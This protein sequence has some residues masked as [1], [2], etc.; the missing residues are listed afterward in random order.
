[1]QPEWYEALP[2]IHPVARLFFLTA[3]A[4][5]G[6][7]TA[8]TA[9][10]AQIIERELHRGIMEGPISLDPQYSVNPAERAVLTDL[11]MGLV[12][13][14]AA[15][16]L[17][18]GVA[19][20]WKTENNG[21]RWVF[22]LRD[23]VKW[24]D[25]RPLVAGDFVYAFQRLLGPRSGAPFASTF[26][27]IAGAQALNEGKNADLN[28][29]GVHAPDKRTV[30]FDLERPMPYFPSMLTIPATFPL[31]K[32]LIERDGEGWTKPGRMVSNG[33]Y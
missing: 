29:L 9:A 12:T 33:P 17:Q 22:T 26:Y 31:R 28:K 19:E 27:G 18:P 25:G 5:L 14:D 8:F 7:A 10:D 2:G 16:K 24:S 6:F 11:F 21:R 1:M 15:G 32:D 23:G 4:F 3:F 20:S 30:V 13:Q